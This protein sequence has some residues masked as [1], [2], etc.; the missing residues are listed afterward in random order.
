MSILLVYFWRVLIILVLLIFWHV[1]SEFVCFG[2]WQQRNW[3]FLRMGSSVIAWRLLFITDK[4][5]PYSQLSNQVKINV[6]LDMRQGKQWVLKNFVKENS[7][8]WKISKDWFE[9][10]QL[11]FVSQINQIRCRM[12]QKILLNCLSIVFWNMQHMWS[13]ILFSLDLPC[14]HSCSCRDLFCWKINKIAYK[15]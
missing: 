7:E 14:S 1:L 15:G 8:Y 5:L 11:H 9:N 10:D 4:Q 12:V 6:F 3:E 13:R 2:F